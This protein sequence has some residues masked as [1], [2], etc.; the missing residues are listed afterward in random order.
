MERT[1]HNPYMMRSVMSAGMQS[2]I[3]AKPKSKQTLKPIGVSSF[4]LKDMKGGL[5]ALRRSR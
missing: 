1:V 4:V 5:T 2:V 3:S